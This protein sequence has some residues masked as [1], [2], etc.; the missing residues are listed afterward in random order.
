MAYVG[1]TR[2]KRTREACVEAGFGL[3]VVRG[4][5]GKAAIDS[6]PFWAYDNLAFGDYQAGRSFDD[7][8]FLADVL[9]MI[10][11]PL[12][13][14]PDFV[15]LP[16]RVAAGLDSLALSRA[17]L[18]RIGR[19]DL[20]WALVVQDGMSPDDIPWDAPFKTIFVGGSTAWKLDTTR[21]WVEAACAHGKR[22]HVGRMGSGVRVAWA[23]TCGVDSIDSSLPLFSADKL[24]VF[25]KAMA[26]PTQGVFAWA[27]PPRVRPLSGGAARK[28]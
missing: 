2:G 9:T 23:K 4:R 13:R 17:W 26:A 15:A 11:L 5:V 16:D 20:R 18:A 8:A 21:N 1:E 28:V 19:L 12:D 14:R 3:L 22:C 6:W 24:S 7:D 27:P 25:K 10:D